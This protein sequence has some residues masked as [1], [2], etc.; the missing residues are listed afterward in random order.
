MHL[1]T[2]KD[3]SV[4]GTY[5]YRVHS[6]DGN[7]GDRHT[8]E[9]MAADLEHAHGKGVVK[10]RHGRRPQPG[11]VYWW[12]HHDETVAS[13]KAELD[14]CEGDRVTKLGKDSFA[15]VGGEGGRRIP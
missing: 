9:D 14:E 3:R 6:A 8:G 12:G 7:S 2:T 5:L 4:K 1:E 11:E 15:C 10:Y 13:D